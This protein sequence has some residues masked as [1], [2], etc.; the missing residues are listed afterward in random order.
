MS[1]HPATA[2]TADLLTNLLRQLHLSTR[3][4]HRELHCGAWTLSGGLETKAMFH[5]V[6]KGQCDLFLEDES[7]P[8]RINHGDVV[9]FPRPL[10]HSLRSVSSPRG[11]VD[12]LLLCGYLEFASPL[13]GIVLDSLPTTLV[14]QGRARNAGGAGALLRLIMAESEH[15]VPGRDA[16]IDKLADALFIYVLR[17]AF[18]EGRDRA[19][20]L[21]GLHDDRL[22]PLLLALHEQPNRPWTLAAMASTVHLSRAALMRRFRAQV[23]MAPAQYLATWRMH[24][25]YIDLT[26]QRISVAAAAHRAGYVT[27]AAFSRAFKRRFGY[28]PIAA[29]RAR[30]AKP[31]S[32]G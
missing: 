26:E 30:G 11:A 28:P 32:R 5:L 3:L 21:R 16:L 31:G 27:E 9:L 18:E 4:F 19:G 6:A 7:Q 23:G 20:L 14:L 15:E 24:R 29:S 12:T 13:A 1:D 10:G 22:R 25:A 2:G 8:L 17:H